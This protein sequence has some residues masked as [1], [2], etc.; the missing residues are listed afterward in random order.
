MK[1][2]FIT[3]EFYHIS[4]IGVDKRKI[5]LQNDDYSRFVRGLYDFNDAKPAL[6]FSRRFNLKKSESDKNVGYQK[7]YVN[8]YGFSLMPNHYHLLL[9]QVQN[10][11][12][13]AYMRKINIGH[14]NAFNKKH[15]RKGYLFEGPFKSKYV[16]DDIRLGFMICYIHS[17]PLDLWKPNWNE[18]GLD[19]KE[20]EQAL[21]FLEKYK[22]SSHL[23]Y[24][25]K[26]QKLS[27]INKDFLL[28][29]FDGTK[30]YKEFFIDWLK[31]HKKNIKH[32]ENYIIE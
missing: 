9:E 15:K 2:G 1:R 5:Y 8:L 18:K 3:N 10:K 31:N 14:T 13:S 23:E 21:R 27:V 30:G 26:K 19:N 7:P 4:N 29:F 12:I 16:K 6:E 22:W 11:G 20:I 17:K 32:I 28:E 25:G 24:L